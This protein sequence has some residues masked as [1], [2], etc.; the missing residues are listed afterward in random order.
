MESSS[1]PGAVLSQL[2]AI[3]RSDPEAD[4]IALLWPT[5]LAQPEIRQQVDDIAVRL[6]YC[7][8]Q[9]AIREQLVTHDASA[10]R[11]VL[12]S[13][14]DES[15]LAKDVLARLWHN[16]PRR[17]SPWKTLQQLLGVSQIDP[18]LTTRELRWVC[19]LLVANYDRLEGRIAHGEVFDLDQAWQALVLVLLDFREPEADWD[20]L[21]QWSLEQSVVARVAGLPE[22]VVARLDDWLAPYLR[23]GEAVVRALWSE[24]HAE[25]L[26]AVGLVCSV[27]YRDDL[28]QDKALF[29][30]QGR[31]SE[32]YLAGMQIP[33]AVLGKYGT[34]A[35]GFAERA[36]RHGRSDLA[37]SLAGAEQILASLDLLPLAVVSDVLPAGLQQRFDRL[38]KA[39]DNAGRG[40]PLA[41]VY[42]ALAALRDH[43][44]AAKRAEQVERAEYAARLCAWLRT[45]AAGD[46][47][48][49]RVAKDFIT[50]GGF[51]DWARA[52]IWSGDPHEGLNR[53]YTRLSRQVRDR[54]EQSNQAFARFLPDLARG[55]DFG[56]AMLPLES[57][58]D[59][60]VAPLATQ[61]PVLLL[62]F[63]GMSQAV[64]RELSEDLSRHGWIELRRE[65]AANGSD[66]LL[67][68]L[69]TITQVCRYSLLAGQ[70]GEGESAA[71]KSAF[72]AHPAL[73]SV[74]NPQYPPQLFH[75]T[76]LQESGSGALAARVREAVAGHRHRVLGAVINAVDDQ[77]SGAAQVAQRW[78]IET[79]SVLVQLLEAAADAGRLVLITSDHGHVLEHDTAYVAGDEEGQRYRNQASRL[80]EHEVAVAGARVVRPGNRVVLPWSER[81]RY[82]KAKANGYHGGGTL[83][84]VIVPFGVWQYA[85]MSQSVEGWREMASVEPDWWRLESDVVPGVM[86]APVTPYTRQA[87]KPPAQTRPAQVTEDLFAPP[88]RPAER[89]T[90]VE[91]WVSALFASPVYREMKE[92]TGRIGISEELLEQLIRQLADGGGQQ[93]S[94]SLANALGIPAI[95]MPGFLAG[96]QKRLNVEGYPVLSIDR[97]AHTVRL[98]I[99][100]LR[101]QFELD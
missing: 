19:E 33:T 82:T 100:L 23:G 67:T 51:V 101:M 13:G 27:L 38:A 80:S 72:G 1:V 84:E 56:E 79:L 28:A 40:K 25:D 73:K 31:L 53:V 4:R 76:D 77:L 16:E 55:D 26:L 94:A 3:F 87:T 35:Q 99:A 98:D 45:P 43:G 90:P 74:S 64:Y 44:H 97:T 11:L 10:E 62:V 2:K 48:A 86:A 17:I 5:P 63:D 8:S 47:G 6:V 60:R 30:A 65:Q 18:R 46:D 42:T 34:A 92:R 66:C 69:P 32:R 12:L 89:A 85:G 21:F 68:A 88:E 14:F 7:P 52:R 29:L 22:E 81:I 75:K 91:R 50:H 59:R 41:P 58:L 57:A 78:R 37:R 61:R 9:L 49:E 24:G 83:Q 15:R 20:A 70:L 96:A 95:R 39:L 71:E 36:L 54:R 93:M